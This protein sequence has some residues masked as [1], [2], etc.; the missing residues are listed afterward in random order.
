MISENNLKET[1]NIYTREGEV[2]TKELNE[3]GFLPSDLTKLV[4][5]KNILERTRKGHYKVNLDELYKYAIKKQEENDL[6]SAFNILYRCHLENKNNIYYIYNLFMVSVL[7]D[8]Y[9]IAIECVRKLVN[10]TSKTFNDSD[11][12]YYFY[13]LN[14]A[15]KLPEDLQETNKYIRFED[16]Q[17]L[18][19]NKEKDIPINRV[20]RKIIDGTFQNIEILEEK[21]TLENKVE[22]KLIELI[23]KRQY[24]EKNY[25]YSLAK[26]KK[27]QDLLEYLNNDLSYRNLNNTERCFVYIINSYF[28][29]EKT[30][31]L[32]RLKDLNCSTVWEAIDNN[33]FR[34]AI[35]IQRE[36][37]EEKG[38]LPHTSTLYL[39]LQEVN[40]MIDSIK[41]LDVS[42][43]KKISPEPKK[44]NISSKENI[45][46]T[47]EL[48]L[49]TLVNKNIDDV[50][51]YIEEYLKDNKEYIYIINYLIKISI[52]EEDITF[53][54]PMMAIS[55]MKSNSF[56]FIVSEYILRFYENLAKKKF[57]ISEVY[58]DILEKAK[59]KGHTNFNIKGMREVLN[60]AL[61]E[62]KDKLKRPSYDFTITNNKPEYTFED[63]NTGYSLKEFINKGIIILDYNQFRI[64]ESIPI[65]QS[66]FY[67]D[68]FVIEYD[69]Y[70]KIVFRYKDTKNI[71]SQDFITKLINDGETSFILGNYINALTIYK[72]ILKKSFTSNA[73]LYNRIG[74]IYLKLNNK[75]YARQCIK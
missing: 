23:K 28:E 72:N 68:P 34:S 52:Y 51:T 20:R 8:K 3:L 75:E 49:E 59:E 1:M 55:V 21:N 12:N 33:N 31:K 19:G 39:L 71:N 62:N 25:M 44:E 69:G 18:T 41:S 43:V 5:E 10:D 38:Q 26:N 47:L 67:I 2:S 14:L 40:E 6:E 37:L 53:S 36:H 64:N 42:N 9:D 7:T 63:L 32:P 66:L 58:L 50:T 57:E 54:K 65:I 29:M 24:E 11:I 74:L 45:N 61:L 35:R 46:V 48:I 27:L 17:V 30:K 56:E 16:I 15:T 73:N 13:L 70:R 22:S 4:H 60:N